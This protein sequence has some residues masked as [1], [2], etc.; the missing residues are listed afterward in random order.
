LIRAGGTAGNSLEALKI[1]RLLKLLR[2][3]RL[4]KMD[5]LADRLNGRVRPA[6]VTLAK[7]VFVFGLVLHLLACTYWATA[8]NIGFD[9]D[10][11]WVPDTSYGYR[12]WEDKYARALHYSILALVGADLQPTY[13]VEYFFQSSSLVIGIILTSCI[14]GSATTILS[15][16]DKMAEEKRDHM[17]KMSAYMKAKNLPLKL[18]HSIYQYYAFLWNSNWAANRVDLFPNL[19]PLLNLQ[20]ELSL[21]QRLI[22]KCALFSNCQPKSVLHLVRRLKSEIAIPDEV[23]FREGEPGRC[24]YF[25]VHGSLSKYRYIKTEADVSARLIEGYANGG[26]TLGDL[27]FFEKDNRYAISIRATTF[28][29]LETLSFQDLA[30]LASLYGDIAVQIQNSA[31]THARLKD[32]EKEGFSYSWSATINEEEKKTAKKQAANELKR[33]DAM[34]KSNLI[35]SPLRTMIKRRMKN[36]VSA[37][38]QFQ[39]NTSF[40][41]VLSEAMRSGSTKFS[42]G[43]S[44]GGQSGGAEAVPQQIQDSVELDSNSDN[45]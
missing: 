23:V 12:P 24:L 37:V 1:I 41:N 16:M 22:K 32:A 44:G 14:I 45:E 13:N 35:D 3:I 27:A 40:K 29:E 10:H 2:L 21:K 18:Q 25:L 8:A 34:M 6:V 39:R 17:N 26:D 28:C 43:G 19:P 30:E 5:K 42:D 9:D 7:L 15:S 11:I 38:S 33:Q 36:K 4:M 20:L 31:K